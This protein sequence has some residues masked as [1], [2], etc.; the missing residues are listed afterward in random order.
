VG[1]SQRFP[2]FYVLTGTSGN[3]CKFHSSL[4]NILPKFN[5]KYMTFEQKIAL[6]LGA[7]VLGGIGYST[8]LITELT[9]F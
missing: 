3:A 2:D 9:S 8:F 6:C 1:L 7:K 5:D 4:V